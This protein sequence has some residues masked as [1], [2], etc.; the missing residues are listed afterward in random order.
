MSSWQQ[1]QVLWALRTGLRDLLGPQG[2]ET[3]PGAKVSRLEKAWMSFRENALKEWL[4][5]CVDGRG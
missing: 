3:T 4:R 5:G 2:G 1:Q